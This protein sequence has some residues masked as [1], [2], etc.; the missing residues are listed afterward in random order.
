MN[1]S[2]LITMITCVVTLTVVTWGSE[3]DS[4]RMELE[5]LSRRLEQLE[6]S[7]KPKAGDIKG[8][9]LEK[10]VSTE[11][12][13]SEE[14]KDTTKE[15]TNTVKRQQLA[16]ELEKKSTL[17][18]VSTEK[19]EEA[20]KE[21]SGALF[22]ET[23]ELLAKLNRKMDRFNSSGFGGS[24]GPT[25]RLMAVD[26]NPLKELLRADMTKRETIGKSRGTK[27]LAEMPGDY[28]TFFLMG[29]FGFG[30]IGN[31]LRIG[32]GG[33]GGS[34]SYRI[35]DAGKDYKLLVEIGYG[36]VIL[37]KAFT[38]NRN[39]FV[40]GTMLGAGTMKVSFGEDSEGSGFNNSSS[41][42]SNNSKSLDYGA[43]SDF[44]L[45][46]LYTG[47]TYSFISWLHLGFEV[48]GNMMNANSGL[49]GSDIRTTFNPTGSLRILFGNLG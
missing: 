47:Y 31:G 19:V 20:E 37:E 34:H 13:A 26:I 45:A 40:I 33:Y 18:S 23:E 6:K 48:G 3:S 29:G 32:G 28:E 10:S 36:G 14:A 41:N 35:S 2:F 21:E 22:L 15:Q 38:Y 43:Y 39:N 4:L 27:F 42:M 46:S 12:V 9:S 24:G 16:K 8:V 49:L 44:F 5:R 7:E 1:R 30:G 25:P 11:T 17:S